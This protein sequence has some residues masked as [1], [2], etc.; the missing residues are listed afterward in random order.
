M[1]FEKMPT[2]ENMKLLLNLFCRRSS[3]AAAL[4]A[5]NYNDKVAWQTWLE[6]QQ[7]KCT[8]SPFSMN[9]VQK[10]IEK[11]KQFYDPIF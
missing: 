1:L 10:S 8:K 3:A 2:I 9:A 7:M 6:L 5:S 11:T 4:Y